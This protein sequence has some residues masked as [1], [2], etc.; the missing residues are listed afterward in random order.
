MQSPSA[1]YLQVPV[2]VA[3]A[4][5]AMPGSLS[6]PRTAAALGVCIEH[7]GQERETKQLIGDLARVGIAALTVR[8]EQELSLGDMVA[9]IDWVR[10]RR[11]LRSLP[12][13]FIAPGSEGA[14]ALKA[15][16]HRPVAV[17]AVL[18][19]RP[20]SPSMQSALRWLRT[21]LAAASKGECRLSVAY[22]A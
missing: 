12:I 15:A 4:R 7:P 8:A 20:D 3:L 18:V 22:S 19:M 17:P 16:Q 6:I 10:S 1:V 21:R 14:A 5:T 11:L 9:L 2:S 13:G